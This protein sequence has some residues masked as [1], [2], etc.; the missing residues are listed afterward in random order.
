MLFL[1]A[2]EETVSRFGIQVHAYALMANHYHLLVRSVRGDLSRAMAYLGGVYTQRANE[3][4]GWDGPLFRGRF[5]SQLVEDETYLRHLLAYLHLNPVKAHKVNRPDESDWTSHA[6]YVGLAKVPMW[7]TTVPLLDELGGPEGVDAFVREAHIGSRPWPDGLN[8]DNGFLFPDAIDRCE[9][10][11]EPFEFDV[12]N[13][14][15]VERLVCEIAGVEPEHLRT[16]VRGPGGNAPRRFAVW[17]LREGA[18]L[19]QKAIGVQ[20]DMSPNHVAQVLRRFD[21]DARPM[22]EWID[23]WH[24]TRFDLQKA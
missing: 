7:L 14:D 19:S 23:R 8:L 18:G 1:C 21:K 17:A 11:H 20:L 22:R 5:A 24:L 13:P 6:A 12:L 9:P 16:S 3:K 15:H 2:L 4:H 10:R